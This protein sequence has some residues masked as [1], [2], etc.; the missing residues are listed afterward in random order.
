MAGDSLPYGAKGS[1]A[2]G[3][4]DGEE[5]SGNFFGDHPRD[6]RVA[7]RKIAQGAHVEHDQ[8]GVNERLHADVN[9]SSDR[10][11]R[12]EELPAPRVTNRHLTAIGRSQVDPNQTAEHERQAWTVTLTV[13]YA[14][15]RDVEVNRI[16]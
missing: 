8:R 11:R 1:P 7:L 14:P 12:T 13:E 6:P 4:Q 9:R 16:R 15:G 10:D 2:E 3:F 5:A